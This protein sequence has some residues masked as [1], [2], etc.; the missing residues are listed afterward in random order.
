MSD[1]PINRMEIW[2]S[3]STG[4][5]ERFLLFSYSAETLHNEPSTPK[6]KA[7]S[8]LDASDFF[9][10]SAAKRNSL[11][12]QL[13]GRSNKLHVQLQLRDF[14]EVRSLGRQLVFVWGGASKFQREAIVAFTVTPIP[15]LT[16]IYIDRHPGCHVYHIRND[17]GVPIKLRRCGAD[18]W[19]LVR[20]K[21]QNT[22]L[23]LFAKDFAVF[24]RQFEWHVDGAARTSLDGFGFLS[25]GT[26]FP[27]GPEVRCQC[28][29]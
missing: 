19:T 25:N 4:G 7:V 27:P 29:S 13:K 8:Q 2:V 1:A 20:A 28:E 6:V 9:L 5:Q 17:A 22:K 16:C 18:V 3:A 14:S 10:F 23:R 24:G 15:G 26:S 11:L 12:K 21:S